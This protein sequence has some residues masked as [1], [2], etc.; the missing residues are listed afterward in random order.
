LQ[1]EQAK[2]PCNQ[3]ASKFGFD[4]LSCRAQSRV[5]LFG[6]EKETGKRVEGYLRSQGGM[7]TFE[8]WLKFKGI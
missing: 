1:F 2:G 3:S 5:L 4:G 6:D 7:F 8:I